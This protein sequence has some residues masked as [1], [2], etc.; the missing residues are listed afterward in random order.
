MHKSIPLKSIYS[1]VTVAELGSMSLAATRLNVSHSAISQAI[2]SLENTLNQP[3]FDRVGRQVKLNRLGHQYYQQVA[4]ALE[5]IVNA[6]NELIKPPQEHRITLNMTNSF[7]MHWWIPKMLSFNEFA[8]QLDIRISN[9]VELTNLESADVDVALIHGKPS[10]RADY[11]CEKLADDEL[12]LVCHPNL[13]SHIAHDNLHAIVQQHAAITVTNPRRKHNW[14]TW[15]EA[16]GFPVPETHNNLRFST[17]LQAIK[18]TVQQLGVLITH[19][20]FVK[21][22]IKNGSLI[23]LGEPILNPYQNFFFV[24]NLD[25]LNNQNIILLR[26]W[27]RNEFQDNN[28]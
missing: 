20:I 7:A 11:Y 27:L 15:C 18:A 1:F 4:P 5:Q 26:Q 21:D 2:K 24:C 16:Y 14:Q 22:D 8:P 19:R 12:I 17:S 23:E 25:K 6:T 13:V 9:L 28:K 10:E 3:L